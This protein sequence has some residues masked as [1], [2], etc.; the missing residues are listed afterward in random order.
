M[1]LKITKAG[2]IIATLLVLSA[3]MAKAADTISVGFDESNPPLMYGADGE[4]KGVYPD[5]IAA[6]FAKMGTPLKL[7]AAP[8]TRV[9]QGADAGTNGVGGIY[10]N[11]TR[12]AKYDYSSAIYEEELA[13]Y[14]TADKTFT[15]NNVED[16][17]GKSIGVIRG[18]S[19]GDDFD[20]A[21]AANKFTVEDVERDQLNVKKLALG[22]LD[23]IIG[24]PVSIDDEVQK[25]GFSGQVKQLSNP[26]SKSPTFLIFAKSAAQTVLITKFNETLAAMRADGSYESTVK[27][28]LGVK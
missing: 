15:Y 3:G 4:A 2:I 9:L 10:K 19:Y 14:T 21:R 28:S 16:L 7:Y 6:I 18:W 25:G 11:A 22:R 20:K 13:I 27:A 5:L 24:I 12:E 17:T 23:A 1:L 26:L 8:W